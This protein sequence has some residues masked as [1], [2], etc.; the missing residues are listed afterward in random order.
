MS[1][2]LNSSE[3]LPEPSSMS[4]AFPS[5]YLLESLEVVRDF[6]CMHRFRWLL[7]LSFIPPFNGYLY[8]FSELCS[9]LRPLRIFGAIFAVQSVC[10]APQWL[11]A[12]IGKARL[13]RAFAHSSLILYYTNTLAAP[14]ISNDTRSFDLLSLEHSKIH[15]LDLFWCGTSLGIR[16]R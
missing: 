16:R 15:I 13:W 9:Y 3:P 4:F 1:E 2:S 10:G 14:P 5:Y 7:S 6:A 12:G 8:A 11:C